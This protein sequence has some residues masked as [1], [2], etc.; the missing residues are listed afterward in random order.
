LSPPIVPTSQN[1][2][3]KVVPFL[4]P[5][6]IVIAFVVVGDLDRLRQRA[7]HVRPHDLAE[8]AFVGVV[9]QIEKARQNKTS[10]RVDVLLPFGR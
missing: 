5:V 8:Q 3:K 4:T 2:R 7:G 10:C 1:S 9:M 6:S